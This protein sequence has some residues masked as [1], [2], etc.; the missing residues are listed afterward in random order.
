MQAAGDRKSEQ[1][2]QYSQFKIPKS[3]P[4]QYWTL[5]RTPSTQGKPPYYV[6]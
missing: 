6:T 1:S 5:I 2:K 3:F 4:K